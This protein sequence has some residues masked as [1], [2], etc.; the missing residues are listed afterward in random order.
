MH[1]PFTD[2]SD[3]PFQRPCRSAH[4]VGYV[5]LSGGRVL[6]DFGA[7]GDDHDEWEDESPPNLDP[8]AGRSHTAP[9]A[10]QALHV[11]EVAANT[12]LNHR[13]LRDWAQFQ[14]GSLW[15]EWQRHSLI[16]FD[17]HLFSNFISSKLP[18][19][20]VIF[21]GIFTPHKLYI[22]ARAIANGDGLRLR[23]LK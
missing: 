22:V 14:P 17:F 20:W 5:R 8:R 12:A 11:G 4:R 10:I 9:G 6:D 7:A 21:H 15:L 1:P 19:I 13:L 3:T 18:T 23:F 16:N 2:G